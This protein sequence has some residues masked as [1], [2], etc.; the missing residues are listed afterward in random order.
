MSDRPEVRTEHC[1]PTSTDGNRIY[2]QINRV[3]RPLVIDLIDQGFQPYEV[4]GLLAEEAMTL[5]AHEAI[6]RRLSA[7]RAS[8]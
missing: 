2:C 8:K 7:H 3:L 6:T 1:G 4:V 5:A